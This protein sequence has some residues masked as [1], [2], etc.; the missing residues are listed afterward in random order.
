[1]TA[2]QVAVLWMLVPAMLWLAAG[3]ARH[4]D[5]RFVLLML[6]TGAFVACLIDVIGVAA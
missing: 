2:L 5:V 3:L 1:M 6:G 4:P